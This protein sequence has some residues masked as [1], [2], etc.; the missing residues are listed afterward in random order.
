MGGRGSTKKKIAVKMK[1]TFSPGPLGPQQ[2]EAPTLKAALGKK[3]EP[4][5][6]GDATVGTNPNYSGDYSEYS[7]NCQR[8]VIAYELRRRGYDVEALPTFEG[9]KL[10]LV[11][12]SKN[13][14]YSG[15][16]R[17]AFQKSKLESVGAKTSQ[18]VIDNIEKRMT[19]FGPGSRAVIQIFYKG[20]GGHVFNV[21]NVGGKVVYIE[22]QTGKV[23]NIQNTLS[24][25]HTGD[26]NFVRTDNLRISERAKRFVRA[27]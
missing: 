3:G 18:G 17:G 26:V 8:C 4:K 14:L 6:I 22:A 11:R 13:K 16:W 9:D 23:K 24:M 7:M 12:Y 25:V 20:G 10:P 27:K 15:A 19:D 1:P 5:S 21:E 2:M